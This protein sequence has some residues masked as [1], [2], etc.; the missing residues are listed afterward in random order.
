MDSITSRIKLKLN[1]KVFKKDPQSSELGLKI[2]SEGINMMEELGLESFNFR[3][4]GSRIE[5]TEASLYRYFDS[6]HH[7]LAYLIMWYWSWMDYQVAMKTINIDD[8]KLRLRNALKVITKEVLVDSEVTH[9]NEVKLNKI[10]VTESTKVYHHKGVEEDNKQG[11][12]IVY[13]ELVHRIASIL[14]EIEP[15]Y[16][17]PH[18][19]IS[20]IIEGAHHQRFFAEYLPRLTDQI[21]GEDSVSCFYINLVESQ[22]G[23]TKIVHS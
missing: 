20:T 6:K 19:L 11:F 10:V 9:V 21:E 18:M 16:K 15:D 2:V 22:L 7:F 13:K 17:Y 1:E 8:P 14:L 12:F 23:L 4:L 3:K 5:S